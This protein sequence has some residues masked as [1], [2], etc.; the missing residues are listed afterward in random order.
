MELRE[1]WALVTG[2]SSGIG[3]ELARQLAGRGMN[4]VITARREARLQALAEELSTKHGVKVDVIAADLSVRDSAQ[5]LFDQT[6]GAGRQIDVL[7]N[8]AGF[9]TLSPFLDKAWEVFDQQMQLNLRTLAQMTHLFATAMK[10]RNCGYLLNVAS[11]G[12]YLPCPQYATYGAGKAF[13]RNFTE[14]LAYELRDSGVKVCCLCPGGTRTEFMEVA[15]HEVAAWQMKFLMPAET[16][17]AIGLRALFAGRR[18][19]ISGYLNSMMMFTLR[20]LPRR[21]CVWIADRVMASS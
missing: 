21:V 15:G 14:A 2:A 9:G 18:N 3:T 10:A 17:A 12:A 6:E 1:R 8:N 11:I 7:I 4:L 13:V 16:C 5:A 20:F 19:I